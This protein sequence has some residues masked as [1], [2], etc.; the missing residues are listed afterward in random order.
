MFMLGHRIKQRTV[1]PTLAVCVICCCMVNL[2][3][4]N[5]ATQYMKYAQQKHQVG[6]TTRYSHRHNIRRRLMACWNVIPRR[7]HL[8]WVSSL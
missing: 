4:A 5:K 7:R 8:G 1:Y 3:D 6:W 2:K